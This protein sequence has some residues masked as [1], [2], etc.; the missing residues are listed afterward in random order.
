MAA[1]H[2]FPPGCLPLLQFCLTQFFCGSLSYCAC[3]PHT[4]PPVTSPPLSFLPSWDDWEPGDKFTMK[5]CFPNDPQFYWKGDSFQNDSFWLALH[6]RLQR[7]LHIFPMRV[8]AGEIKP[9]CTDSGKHS[10]SPTPSI[11]LWGGPVIRLFQV[12]ALE[13]GKNIFNPIM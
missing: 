13:E 12:M 5:L 2:G 8:L 10:L 11:I 4:H 6:R 9:E 7:F 3:G 1:I